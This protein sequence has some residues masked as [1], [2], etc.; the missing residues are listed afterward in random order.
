[1]K[2][3]MM[4]WAIGVLMICTLGGCMKQLKGPDMGER[5]KDAPPIRMDDSEDVHVLVMRAPNPGWSFWVERDERTRE[6]KRV[7]VTMRRPD[8]AMLYPSVIVEK[9]LR[10]RVR[11]DTPIEIYARLLDFDESTRGRGHQRIEP[12]E[13]FSE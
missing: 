12:V 4:A 9:N 2:T 1:M 5:L 3:W 13:S 7:Y 11:T 8:P 10:T 6:G